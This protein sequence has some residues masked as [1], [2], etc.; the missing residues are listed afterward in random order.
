LCFTE[1]PVLI[2]P[3][4]NTR[5]WKN[6]LTQENLH[7][8][9]KLPNFSVVEPTAGHLA[10]GETGEGHLAESETIL[11]ALYRQ[12]HPD[13]EIFRGIRAVVTAGGTSEPVDPVR[14]ISN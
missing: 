4:M 14:V 12:L 8:L 11:Q 9:R 3:A 2:A 7:R 5:M 6:P 10:C 1:K 13:K